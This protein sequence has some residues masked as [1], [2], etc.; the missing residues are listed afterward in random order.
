MIMDTKKGNLLKFVF[1]HPT[2]EYTVREIARKTGMSPTWISK[3]SR[4][5]A[6]ADLVT[7]KEE[8]TSKKISAKK[9]Q[10]F[11]RKKRVFNLD[12]VYGSGVV[13]KLA[14]EYAHPDAIVLF[15][16]YSKGEDTEKSDIDI[17]IISQR[18]KAEVSLKAYEKKLERQ[19]HV[20]IVSPEETTKE[21]GMTLAN[22]VVLYGYLER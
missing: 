5:L 18:K 2:G 22:G 17:A 6:K 10:T 3:I 15:G 12:S 14:E 9:G 7:I 11:I 16:S 8:T 13:D 21:F 1:L 4:E 19:I 20:V